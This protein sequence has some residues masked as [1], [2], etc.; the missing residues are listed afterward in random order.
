MLVADVTV[1]KVEDFD[2]S[3]G[4]GFKHA[5]PG[6]G[7]Q[8]FGLN[9]IDIPPGYDG[10]PEHDHSADGQEEVYIA[11]AGSATLNAG[12]EE[13]RLE[14]GVMARVGPGV[15]RKIVTTDESVSLIAIGGIPGQAYE[16]G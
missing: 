15:R 2:A 9:V 16:A 13:H 3:M 6:L 14:P 12:G 11:V 1:K 10:Y 7:V 8:S 4:G 5:R